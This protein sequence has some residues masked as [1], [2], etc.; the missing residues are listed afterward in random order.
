MRPMPFLTG[1]GL[2][3]AIGLIVAAQVHGWAA[4]E[5]ASTS[6]PTACEVRPAHPLPGRKR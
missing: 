4:D 1:I 5:A 3:I 6:T 2:G